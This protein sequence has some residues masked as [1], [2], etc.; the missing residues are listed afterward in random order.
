MSA[1]NL[2]KESVVQSEI[3]QKIYYKHIPGTKSNILIIHGWAEHSGRYEQLMKNL[4]RA[5]YGVICPDL[6][7]HGK[8]S[9]QRGHV[10]HWNDYLKDLDAVMQHVSQAFGKNKLFVIGH[11]MGG[12]IA[13]RFASE[14]AEKYQIGGLITSGAL[15][16]L[17]MD[18]A[19]L[20]IMMGKFLSKLIPRFS[21]AQNLKAEDLTRDPE[22]IRLRDIDPLIHNRV[23]ARW[24]TELNAEMQSIKK[25]APDI[26]IPVLILHGKIDPINSIE[27]S[28]EFFKLVGSTDKRIKLYPG[29]VHEIFNEIGREIVV[30]EMVNWL[31]IHNK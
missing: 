30:S 17:K 10:L 22:I 9:G 19:P 23:S 26:K 1:D 18:V 20:K 25:V 21:M 16:K 8:S 14:F 15:L 27:G 28:E 2:I 31:D 5:G 29:M 13:I 24:Y 11:S 7:G 6:R 3:R 12:V 4:Q